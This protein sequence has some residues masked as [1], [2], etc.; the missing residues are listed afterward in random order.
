MKPGTRQ[1]MH[2]MI[3]QIREVL[4][5]DLDRDEVCSG[6][7]RGCSVKLLDYM[8]LELENWRYRLD[9]GE[10]PNFRD[11]SKLASSG[12]KVHRALSRN[13]LIRQTV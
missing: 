13:G 10:T 6:E 3:G 12:K 11:L 8:D 9:S 2:N 1:A 5:F 4:P 7:C